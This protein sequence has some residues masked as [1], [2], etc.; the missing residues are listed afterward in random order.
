MQVYY[1]FVLNFTIY[2]FFMLEKFLL[3]TIL[4]STH[5]N[6]IYCFGRK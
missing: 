3:G 6:Y 4:Q 1:T 5:S 2:A